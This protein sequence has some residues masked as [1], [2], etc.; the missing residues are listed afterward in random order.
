MILQIL[1]LFL[2]TVIPISAELGRWVVTIGLSTAPVIYLC[3]A[4]SGV[5]LSWFVVFAD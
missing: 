4:S 5:S 2:G 3:T 1:F